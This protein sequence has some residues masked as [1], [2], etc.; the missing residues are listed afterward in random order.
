M[1]N[2]DAAIGR[3]KESS[4]RTCPEC[5][6]LLYS[7]MDKLCIGLYEKCPVHLEDD[8]IEEKNLLKISEAL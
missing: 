3:A 8:S 6:E 1:E 7:P 5:G 2:I 4:P